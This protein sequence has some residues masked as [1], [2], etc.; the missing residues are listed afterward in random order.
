LPYFRA[1]LPRRRGLH[2]QI[3]VAPE[4]GCDRVERKNSARSR[5][6]REILWRWCRGDGASFGH[7]MF[8]GVAVEFSSVLRTGSH[9]TFT[10]DDH[11]TFHLSRPPLISGNEPWGARVLM[12][13]HLSRGVI[14]DSKNRAGRVQSRGIPFAQ[15]I[16]RLQR[17][18]DFA[19]LLIAF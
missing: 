1:G 2:Q 6:K 8:V 18:D 17:D 19:D 13:P 7:G 11:D 9:S 5:D 15:T 4:F 12:R 3:R 10:N 16:R 14:L